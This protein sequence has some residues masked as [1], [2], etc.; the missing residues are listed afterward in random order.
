MSIETGSKPEHKA[1]EIV[2]NGTEVEVR[3]RELTFE[4]LVELAELDAA[5]DV[6]YSV[7]YSRGP[8]EAASGLLRPGQSVKVRKGMRFVVKAT[9]RS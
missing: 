4:S 7:K 6:E 2:I 5:G 8:H 3:E 9:V 1:I